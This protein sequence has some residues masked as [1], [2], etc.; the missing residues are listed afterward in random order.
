MLG[1]KL[2]ALT[3]GIGMFAVALGLVI[4]DLL[5]GYKYRRAPDTGATA[6]VEP[7]PASWRMTVALVALSWVPMI[8]AFS[9]VRHG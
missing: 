2:I 8:I 4:Y 1:M 5:A 9:L 6:P 3:L 7:E